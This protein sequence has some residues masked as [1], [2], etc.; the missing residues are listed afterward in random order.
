MTKTTLDLE[1]TQKTQLLQSSD[2]KESHLAST[3]FSQSKCPLR[4]IGKV[5]D[6]DGEKFMPQE[7]P[8]TANFFI[9]LLNHQ[10]HCHSWNVLLHLGFLCKA[11][12]AQ[13]SC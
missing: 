1:A 7:T 5:I 10:S 2:E 3:S 4:Q 6:R 13:Y 9:E 11:S 8:R 12:L